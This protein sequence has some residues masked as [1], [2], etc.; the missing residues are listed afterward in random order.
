M[1]KQRFPC[2]R[3]PMVFLLLKPVFCCIQFYF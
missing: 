3:S 2:Y 1:Q